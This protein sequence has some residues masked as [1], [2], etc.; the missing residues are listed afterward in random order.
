MPDTDPT[1]INFGDNS[2]KSIFRK[3]GLAA[4]VGAVLALGV[5]ATPA[6]AAPD[7]NFSVNPLAVTLAGNGLATV[8]PALDLRAPFTAD[9]I[10][11]LSSEL[12]HDIGGNTLAGSGYLRFDKFSDNGLPK[13]DV[14]TGLNGDSTPQMF[15]GYQ[16]YLDFFI[17]A[18]LASGTFGAVGST[19]TLNALNFAVYIDP[20][21][22][23]VFTSADAA[24]GAGQ[25][26]SSGTAGQKANDKLLA[27]GGLVSGN[28]AINA[29][30][31]A[32]NTVQFLALCDGTNSASLGGLPVAQP[33]CTSL[34]TSFFTSPTPFYSIALDAFNNDSSKTTNNL[35]GN[36]T[37]SIRDAVGTVSFAAVPEPTSVALLGIALAGLG[38]SARRKKQSAA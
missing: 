20:N 13:S 11:G 18:T 36:G 31:A 25:E 10:S 32:I 29:G 22:D 28:A 33:G 30:G 24:I 5:A 2:M 1:A 12:L 19:Y 27:V 26:A 7:F 17:S 34:G 16:L 9:Q 38:F 8:L 23:N 21:R 35:A 14:I 6:S 37:V 4:A 3:T 15:A